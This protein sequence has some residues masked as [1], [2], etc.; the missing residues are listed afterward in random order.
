M[1][2]GGDR[3]DPEGAGSLLGI[4]FTGVA[5]VV[6]G[7]GRGVLNALELPLTTTPEATARWWVGCGYE[8]LAVDEQEP[9]GD[10]VKEEEA[11]DSRR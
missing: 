9:V 2:S 5:G 6:V 11:I 8:M 4:L 7:P 1:P 3:R 10:R